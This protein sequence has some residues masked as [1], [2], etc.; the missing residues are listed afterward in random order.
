[1]N[2]YAM[3][4]RYNEHTGEAIFEGV[5]QETQRRIYFVYR[6]LSCDNTRYQFAS[7]CNSVHAKECFEGLGNH[8]PLACRDVTDGS[9]QNLI[10]LSLG[11]PPSKPP[12]CTLVNVPIVSFVGEC[13]T[14]SILE[15][16]A[17]D[18]FE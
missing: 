17:H 2:L 12:S 18:G 9:V 14:I 16:V 7:F 1:M 5:V 8:E 15:R 11:S 3:L 10:L 6:N 4:I 13:F